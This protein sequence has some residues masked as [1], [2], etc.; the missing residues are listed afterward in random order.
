M[1]YLQT[2]YSQ[3][4]S[5]FSVGARPTVSVLICTRNRGS[6]LLP[7]VQSILNNT[8]ENFEL[9]IVDQSVN[10]ETALALASLRSDSRLRYIRSATV[11]LGRARNIGIGHAATDCVLMTDDDCEVPTDWIEKMARQFAEWPQ[12]A[13]SFCIVEA[14]LYD[15]T[16][17]F[18][19][20]YTCK[21]DRL[22]T[23]VRDRCS[24]HGIGAGMAVRKSAVQ[25]FG[26]FDEMLGAGAAFCSFED[27]D[28]ALRAL[29][30]GYQVYMT[31][32][33][34]VLHHGFRNWAEVRGLI[35]RDFMAIGAGHAKL[36][37]CGRWEVL[38]VCAFDLWRLVLGPCLWHLVRLQKPRVLTRGTSFLKGFVRGWKAP[39]DRT[40]MTFT[41]PQA[42]FTEALV[43]SR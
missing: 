13:V 10:D 39:V 30:N 26:G 27:G 18:T 35:Q 11:G 21:K 9:L 43:S 34:A 6:M 24:A 15:P 5:E 19:P 33:V 17:G 1:S 7:T 8:Y 22:L 37:K 40:T 36:L 41:N 12:I 25:A 38:P 3:N 28:I 23:S 29:L 4:E 42:E 20:V 14:A 16:T 2:E 32:E 31:K